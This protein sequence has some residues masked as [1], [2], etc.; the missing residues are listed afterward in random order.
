MPASAPTELKAWNTGTASTSQ[1][2][3]ASTGAAAAGDLIVVGA[4]CAGDNF[5]NLIDSKGNTYNRTIHQVGTS[6]G[7]TLLMA[8]AKVEAGKEI[9]TSTTWTF[10]LNIADTVAC[11]VEK[12]TDIAASP[13]DGSGQNIPAPAGTT[14]ACPLS[15][16]TTQADD[17]LVGGLAINPSGSTFTPEV[18]SPVW[19]PMAGSPI[20]T[21]TTGVRRLH[22][23][24]RNVS[25][26]ATWA[27]NGTT[28]STITSAAA[29]ILAFKA[30]AAGPTAPRVD[31]SIG[32]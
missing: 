8:W 30:T 13:L 7:V 16:S 2:T 21:L 12:Y 28:G 11:L 5:T 31:I 32:A 18:V 22:L 15:G 19:T 4:V 25:S 23:L 10:T 6:G 24:S 29:G 14:V 26:T 27:F 9:D 17:L 20:N 1:Q 3:T